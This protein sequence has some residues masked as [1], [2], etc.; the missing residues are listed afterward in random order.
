MTQTFLKSWAGASGDLHRDVSQPASQTPSHTHTHTR[1]IAPS[2]H[3]HLPVHLSCTWRPDLYSEPPAEAGVSL[4]H[5][6]EPFALLLPFFPLFPNSSCF[7]FSPSSGFPFSFFLDRRC[8]PSYPWAQLLWLVPD[9]PLSS[10]C[11]LNIPQLETA[12]TLTHT[13]THTHTYSLSHTHTHTHTLFA[14]SPPTFPLYLSPTQR[15]KEAFFF[16]V[17]FFMAVSEPQ[18]EKAPEHSS[19]QEDRNALRG[20]SRRKKENVWAGKWNAHYG[21]YKAQTWNLQKLFFA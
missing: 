5:T 10:S 13:H 6:T 14:P 16:C 1:A 17:F 19:E 15:A 12:H 4:W 3:H 7:P 2:H 9:V 20:K 8:D 21:H 11:R 18:S